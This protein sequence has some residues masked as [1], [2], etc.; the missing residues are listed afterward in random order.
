M[1]YWPEYANPLI[2]VTVAPVS[3]QVVH[4]R[5]QQHNEVRLEV[6]ISARQHMLPMSLL[7]HERE[8]TT[9]RRLVPDT[10]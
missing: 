5:D 6:S 4:I 8:Q 3:F 2:A 9:P 7:Q 1:Y 10:G